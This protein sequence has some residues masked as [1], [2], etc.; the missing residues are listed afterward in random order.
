[1]RASLR[2]RLQRLEEATTDTRCCINY[3]L[4]AGLDVCE[5]KKIT[6]PS[7][8]VA[9]LRNRGWRATA[10]LPDTQYSR[11]DMEYGFYGKVE[12]YPPNLKTISTFAR[13]FKKGT[14]LLNL[15]TGF[16]VLRDG[17]LFDYEDRGI[18]RRRIV[19]AYRLER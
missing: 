5:P 15:S 13:Q 6:T 3:A 4:A 11:M 18:N 10:M 1:M 14:F 2:A 17:R 7:K 12:M 16:A 19:S 8:I 9:L